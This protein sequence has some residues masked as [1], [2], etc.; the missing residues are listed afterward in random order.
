MQ[1]SKVDSLEEWM[2]FE[3]IYPMDGLSS[4]LIDS[5]C[6]KSLRRVYFQEL[7]YKI[8][9]VLRDKLVHLELTCNNPGE[10]WIGWARFER[11][12]T[13]E[14]LVDYDPEGPK[15]GQ[16]SSLLALDNFRGYIGFSSD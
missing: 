14:D 9:S 16:Y 8:L 2:A 3:L 11:C 5:V 10:G 4:H 13:S 6:S 1:S 7:L 12:F 15:I